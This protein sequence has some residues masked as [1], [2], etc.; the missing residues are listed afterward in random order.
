MSSHQHQRR[1][2]A[3]FPHFGTCRIPAAPRRRRRCRC[4]QV[5]IAD[6][7]T[8]KGL[9]KALVP[10]TAPRA[11]ARHWNGRQRPVRTRCPART[12]DIPERVHSSRS[13]RSRR[14]LTRQYRLCD[15]LV[16]QWAALPLRRQSSW[17]SDLEIDPVMALS[18][19]LVLSRSLRINAAGLIH[20]P[21][22]EQGDECPTL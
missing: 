14:I 5:V 1:L 12:A 10:R 19:R 17:N 15:D 2:R 18:Q 9:S 16:A 20:P 11:S 4:V 3:L 21:I 8:A 13:V 7:I 22:T 6:A